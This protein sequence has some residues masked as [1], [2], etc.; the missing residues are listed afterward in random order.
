MKMGRFLFRDYSGDE[1][2]IKGLKKRLVLTD[3]Y[4]KGR[5]CLRGKGRTKNKKMSKYKGLVRSG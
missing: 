3:V 4:T 1:R 2:T 5:N